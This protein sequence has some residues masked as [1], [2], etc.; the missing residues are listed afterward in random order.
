VGVQQVTESDDLM[1][2]TK[3]GKTIRFAAA[4]IP[5]LGRDTQGVKL[6]DTGVD[7]IIGTALVRDG[8]LEDEGGE[9]Q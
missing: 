4:A 3:N 6:M 5:V 7:E 1:L 8:G 2:I 9:E